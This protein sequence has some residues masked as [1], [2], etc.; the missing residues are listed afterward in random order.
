MML[1]R[2]QRTIVTAAERAPLI[3]RRVDA[4]PVALP[5]KAPMKMAG[6]TITGRRCTVLS[7]EIA[8]PIRRWRWRCSTSRAGYPA[9]D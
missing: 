6:I 5:L 8:A 3:V 1:E 7:S 4:I 2:T 9:A